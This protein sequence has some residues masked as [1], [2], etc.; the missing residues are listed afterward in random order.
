MRA[1]P[2]RL[3][4]QCTAVISTDCGILSECKACHCRTGKQGAAGQARAEDF[5][6]SPISHK[7]TSRI[8]HHCH[9]QQR[10]RPPSKCAHVV[11]QHER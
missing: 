2:H 1:E 3:A 7:L 6:T 4:I 5:K 9:P 8:I 11:V 10:A